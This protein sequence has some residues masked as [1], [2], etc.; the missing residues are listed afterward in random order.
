MRRSARALSAA[1]LAGAVLGIA[2]PAA[3]AEPTA[4]VA[5]S[6]VSPGGSVTVSVTCDPTGGSPPDTMDATSDAFEEGTVQLRLVTGDDEELP[7]YSGTVKI[8]PAEDLEG[9]TEEGGTEEGGTEEVGPEEVGTEEVGP[10]EVGQDSAW[11]VDGT[12]PTAPGGQGTQWSAT[13]TVSHGSGKSCDTG[14]HGDSCATTSPCT[15]P[16]TGSCATTP[17]CVEAHAGSCATPPACVEAH[18]DSCGGA[19]VRRGVR[20]GEGGTFTDSVPALAAGGLL[21]AGALGGAV[22]RLRRKGPT[23]GN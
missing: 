21:I 11:T 12:C 15:D 17:A 10:E 6:S 3:L 23:T 9:G 16:H 2:A 8:A 20:A 7:A 1:A 18:T 19:V 14:S 13:F 5:P 4:E 22:Y